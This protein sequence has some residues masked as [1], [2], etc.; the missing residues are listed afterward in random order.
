MADRSRCT[1]GTPT[2]IFLS[3]A[4]TRPTLMRYLAKAGFTQ[5]YTYFTWRN[6]K[7]ELTEYFTELTDDRGARVPAAEPVRQHARHPARVPAARRPSRVR[8]AAAPGGDARRELRHLQ[9]LRAVR[10]P[11]R[12]PGTEEYADSEKYQFRKWDWDRPGTSQELVVPRQ[13]RS[14]TRTA[15]C[16]ST[17]RCGFTTT[18]NPQIIAYSKTRAG[19]LRAGCST[20]VNLD[21]HHMQHGLRRRARFGRTTP[22]PFAI[23]STTSSYTW[24]GE[25]N[26]VRFDPGHPPRTHPVATET[27]AT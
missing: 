3:E 18:D 7:A 8:G 13:R 11:A 17:A 12:S 20:I 26:Y 27:A 1:R 23:C 6:T 5:S 24:R 10:G 15:R 19:R 21:P 4:F 16:S 14:G 22:S 2:C 9:R 25:W